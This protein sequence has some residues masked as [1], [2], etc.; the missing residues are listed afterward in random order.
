MR[1][2]EPVALMAFEHILNFVFNRDRDR[3]N[4]I[5]Y[6]HGP[7]PLLGELQGGWL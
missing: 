4:L 3:V 6:K 5:L 2:L 1:Q 7:E